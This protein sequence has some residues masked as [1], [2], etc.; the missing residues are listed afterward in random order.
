MVVLLIESKTDNRIAQYLQLRIDNDSVDTSIN[1]NTV[2]DTVYYCNEYYDYTIVDTVRCNCFVFIKSVSIKNN[3]RCKEWSTDPFEDSSDEYVEYCPDELHIASR[4][5]TYAIIRLPELGNIFGPG[6]EESQLFEESDIQTYCI[7]DLWR[8]VA[9]IRYANI[10]AINLFSPPL[11]TENN[12]GNNEHN[13]VNYITSQY[14][15]LFPEKFNLESNAEATKYLCQ[16][17]HIC[18]NRYIAEKITFYKNLLTT[19]QNLVVSDDLWND[20]DEHD[21][22]RIYRNQLKTQKVVTF[23]KQIG[24]NKLDICP[25]NYISEWKYFN[26]HEFKKNV[27]SSIGD[28]EIYSIN[29]CFQGIDC[30]LYEDKGKNSCIYKFESHLMR[31]VDIANLLKCKHVIYNDKHTQAL[32]WNEQDKYKTTTE[33]IQLFIN[34]FNKIGLTLNKKPACDVII[35]IV[36]PEFMNCDVFHNIVKVINS[37]HIKI[38]C[39][40]A[41]S[42]SDPEVNQ[43]TAIF[44]HNAYVDEAQA[45]LEKDY[46]V[47][48]SRNNQIVSINCLDDVYRYILDCIKLKKSNM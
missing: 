19:R 18:S 28:C 26:I 8:D 45:I 31:I 7:D 30:C 9:E 16:Q 29:S 34:M 6:F 46:I 47:S 38:A 44:I 17:I 10:K 37:K 32:T 5:Q 20:C 48:R 42:Q 40:D 33:A 15:W 25:T 27:F 12:N 1:I 11:L 41:K 35:C 3:I 4:F 2:Y 13:K 23:M 21:K 24:L 14:A 43:N 36:K 39:L 22:S